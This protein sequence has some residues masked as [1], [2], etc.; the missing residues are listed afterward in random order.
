VV[1]QS[2]LVVGWWLLGVMLFAGSAFADIPPA[3]QCRV[4][5]EDKACNNAVV[6]DEPGKPGICKKDTCTRATPEGPMSYSCYTCKPVAAG[7]GGAGG[8]PSEP[9]PPQPT[10]GTKATDTKSEAED[11]AGCTL[12]AVPLGQ[13]SGLAA[14]A[15]AAGLMLVRR[16][17]R[18]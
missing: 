5:D 4:A 9:E 11:D 3:D 2:R 10:A 14:A 12:V 1:K 17:T 8:Q 7:A 16:R 6:D 18:D 15:I 13:R